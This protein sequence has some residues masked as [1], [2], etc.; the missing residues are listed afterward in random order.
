MRVE[1]RFDEWE[2]ELRSGVDLSTQTALPR[3]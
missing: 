2:D 3:D 1:R